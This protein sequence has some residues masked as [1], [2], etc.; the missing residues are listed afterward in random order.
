MTGVNILL[1]TYMC[2]KGRSY[3]KY[4]YHKIII[5]RKQKEIL[6]SMYRFMAYTVAMVSWCTPHKLSKV[7]IN[8]VQF[9]A[10]QKIL[11]DENVDEFSDKSSYTHTHTHTMKTSVF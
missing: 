2:L 1:C 4:S 5:S 8:Y 9:F 11:K 6:V 10:G 3:V 7:Y